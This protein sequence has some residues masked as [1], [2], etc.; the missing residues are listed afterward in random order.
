MMLPAA[1]LTLLLFSGPHIA[2]AQEARGLSLEMEFG[3]VWQ[4]RNDA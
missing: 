4:T 2:T 1:F 3:P